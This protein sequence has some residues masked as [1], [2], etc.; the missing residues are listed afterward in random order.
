MPRKNV[1][2]NWSEMGVAMMLA[3]PSVVTV[4]HL[5]ASEKPVNLECPNLEAYKVDLMC[6]K[7]ADVQKVMDSFRRQIPAWTSP[8]RRV[9]LVGKHVATYPALAKL[10]D[11]NDVKNSKADVYLEFED[12]TYAGISCK[13]SK[14]ATIT[15]F[16]VEKMFD[17]V[18]RQMCAQIRATVLKRFATLSDD[19]TARNFYHGVPNE[20]WSTLRKYIGLYGTVVKNTLVAG[21]YARNTPYQ[22]YE[23][24]G[25]EM[26]NLS[27]LSAPKQVQFREYLE[28]YKHA[29]RAAKMFYLLKV[30]D[31]SYR[32]E[33]RWKGHFRGSP[34]FL[35]HRIYSNTNGSM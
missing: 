25:S 15:N 23:F 19:E 31:A 4:A 33:V 18:I 5:K 22:M 6:R 13:A 30:D 26:V 28:H 29:P 16:S 35:T 14:D 20:Y 2:T 27:S 12:G 17:P 32:V 1:E 9:F 3:D 11:G 21:I 7:E 10:N 34:Q 24:N 8:I